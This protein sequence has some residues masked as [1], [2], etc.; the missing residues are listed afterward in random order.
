MYIQK[1]NEN[2]TM[3]CVSDK[4]MIWETSLQDNGR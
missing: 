1:K 3:G 4:I 2:N